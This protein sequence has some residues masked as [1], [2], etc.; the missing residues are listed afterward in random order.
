MKKLIILAVACT[1]ALAAVP[2]TASAFKGACHIEGTATLGAPIP[3]TGHGHIK[4]T[5]KF[6]SSGGT[7]AG[8]EA[9]GGASVEGEGELGCESSVS[10]SGHGSITVGGKTDEIAKFA[11]T[12]KGTEVMFEAEGPEVHSVN[13]SGPALGEASFA[14]D[15][16]AV[17]KCEPLSPAG[18]TALKFHAVTQGEFK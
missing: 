12:G 8:G 3:P 9:F 14:L 13:G 7:C 11:F 4:T 16:E 15:S 10:T 18:P 1:A 17:K 6:A 5:Y 2:A